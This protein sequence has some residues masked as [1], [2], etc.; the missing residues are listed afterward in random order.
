MS[1]IAPGNEQVDAFR[2]QAASSRIWAR[3]TRLSWRAG[4][5]SIN[6]DGVVSG[7]SAGGYDAAIDRHGTDI[8]LG[9]LAGLGSVALDLNDSGQ[10]VGFSPTASLPAANGSSQPTLI[11]HAFLY[12]HGK[13]TDL[14]TLGG[15]DSSADSIND[16]GAVVGSLTPRTTR[17]TTPS[18]TARGG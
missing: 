6:A 12:S 11:V 17:Q 7:L 5:V 2:E 14:G 3:S 9:S 15:T 18:S 13:M 1:N 4:V 8:E 16:R 10:V